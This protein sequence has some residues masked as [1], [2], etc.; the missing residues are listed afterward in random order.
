MELSAKSEYALLALLEMST[1][2]KQAEPLQIR[3]IAA[4]HNIPDR[5]LEQ[6]MATLRR[7]GLI[8][9]QRGARGGYLLAKA[10]WQISILDVLNCIEGMDS[11]LEQKLPDSGDLARSL[12]RSIWL[13]ACAAANEVLRKHT[14]QD[15]CDRRQAYQQ[16]DVM[17]YI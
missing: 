5:Y 1:A 15:L 3:Q 6:L 16:A 12:I 17:Y 11:K 14:L 4:M 10:P 13:E 2:Y 7:K 9:S 8:R